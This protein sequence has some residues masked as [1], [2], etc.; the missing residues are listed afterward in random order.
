MKRISA[1]IGLAVLTTALAACT[2]NGSGSANFVPQTQARHS[3]D[4]GGSGRPASEI[5]TTS[6]DVGGSGVPG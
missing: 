5:M 1:Y 3:T 6:D 2:G 4:V